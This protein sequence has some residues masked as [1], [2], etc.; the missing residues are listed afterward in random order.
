MRYLTA[1]QEKIWYKKMLDLEKRLI[2][3]YATKAANPTTMEPDGSFCMS[4][5]KD[6]YYLRGRV[7][8]NR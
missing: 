1:R 3:Y 6:G 8:P 5:F 2:A 4:A 7:D